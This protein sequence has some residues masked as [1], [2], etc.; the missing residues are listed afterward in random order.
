MREPILE[1]RDLTKTFKS[2]RAVNAVKLSVQTG[3]IHAVI[4]PN[5]A[6]KSTLFKLITGVYVPSAGEVLLDGLAIGGER[7]HEIARKGL[8]QVFQLTSIFG[9]LSVFDSVMVAAMAKRH[10]P[11]DL[12]GRFRKKLSGEV[13]SLL[14]IVGISHLGGR[15]SG[16]LSHGDQR[17]LELAM[18]LATKPSVLLLDEPTAG[19]SPAETTTIA[20]LI[21]SIA[22]SSN[23]T[24]LLSE[25]DMDVIFTISNRVTVLHQGAVIAEGTPE[26]IRKIPEVMAVYL[27]EQPTG[28]VVVGKGPLPRR[29][30]PARSSETKIDSLRQKESRP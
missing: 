20:S 19:M 15:I 2:F 22:R 16:E 9:R 3:S 1:V 21:V 25:H 6:G 7:P 30:S 18:A 13:E 26:E 28:R 24:V 5:G 29:T 23:I 8:V 10:R 14:D 11:I 12:S 4:G 17:A 27:G